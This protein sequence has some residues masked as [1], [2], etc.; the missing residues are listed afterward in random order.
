MAADGAT[1]DGYANQAAFQGAADGVF[2]PCNGLV[3]AVMLCDKSIS[4]GKRNGNK[5]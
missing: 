3:M 5:H 1:Y 2:M 4:L